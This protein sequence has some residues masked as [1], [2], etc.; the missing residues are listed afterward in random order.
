MKFTDN[1]GRV[2]FNADYCPE[3]VGETVRRLGNHCHIEMVEMSEAE[4]SAIP[5][6]NESAELWRTT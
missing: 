2:F 4:Y 6:T 5:A 3:L 1:D